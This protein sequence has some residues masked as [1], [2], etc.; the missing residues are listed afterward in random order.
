MPHAAK[1]KKNSLLRYWA[2]FLA[3]LL[4]VTLFGIFIYLYNLNANQ[5]Y[6]DQMRLYSFQQASTQLGYIFEQSKNLA[7]DANLAPPSS[8]FPQTGPLS[9]E[10]QIVLEKLNELEKQAVVES[11]AFYYVRGQAGL[12]SSGGR[13]TYEQFQMD[14]S[15]YNFTYAR[16]F[17]Q[18]NQAEASYVCRIPSYD[19]T[20]ALIAVLCPFATRRGL[21]DI[22][23]FFLIEEDI[24]MEKF[25]QYF[26]DSKGEVYVYTNRLNIVL[27]TQQPV[28][29]I[30]SLLRYKG[31][32]LIF[33]PDS[34]EVAL[35]HTV[36]NSLNI[37]S[38]MSRN[39][40]Y[41]ELRRNQGMLILLITVMIV[42]CVIIAVLGVRHTYQPLRRLTQD[43]LGANG[44]RKHKDNLEL[45][46]EA[47]DTS[48][49]RSRSL[50]NQISS[51]NKMLSSQFVLRLISGK[52]KSMEE[53]HYHA[54]CFGLTVERQYWVV[55]QLVI[56]PFPGSRQMI[57]KLLED[58][59]NFQSPGVIG[60]YSEFLMHPGICCLFHFDCDGSAQQFCEDL[61]E[62]LCQFVQG[63]G[64]QS[65]QIGVGS[66]CTNPMDARRSSYEA[67]AAMEDGAKDDNRYLYFYQP[68]QLAQTDDFSIPVMEKSVLAN[69]IS[70]GDTDVALQA[71]DMLIDYIEA[72]SHSFLLVRYHCSELTNL[73]L[74]LAQT[75][76]IPYRQKN[77]T[78]LAAYDNLDL[79]RRSSREL[80]E[81]LCLQ[82]QERQELDNI[83]KKGEVLTFI[84]QNFTRDDFSLDLTASSLNLTKSKISAI[85]KEDIGMG[86]PQYISMLRINEVKRQL[87]ETKKPIQDVIRDVGYLDV[88]NFIRRFKNLEGMTPGQYRTLNQKE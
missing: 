32:G 4:P 42:C 31:L 72:S 83:M 76:G 80:T 51:Q 29:P 79:F 17:S 66:P 60:L 35:R 74:R 46:R 10:E 8:V 67:D 65:F 86:F 68:G 1:D 22:D 7:A 2:A 33:P 40:F 50:M 38:I 47:F 14:H 18:L 28:P 77:W 87:V 21:S 78:A 57:D 3:F 84:A 5:N 49:E 25:E 6:I 26:G 43:I 59:G 55:M 71:L 61:A 56:P 27:S 45:I 30:E 44:P 41:Q 53:I 58:S 69:G 11:Q 24:L 23:V 63:E 12:Y 36:N 20:S 19:N 75:N 52:F 88:S 37:V 16:F 54:R 82:I 48:Q 62:R 70:H 13:K 15:G 9:E 64:L 81:H 39:E 73:L 85:L 34:D